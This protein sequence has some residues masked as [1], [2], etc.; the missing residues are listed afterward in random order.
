MQKPET[1]ICTHQFDCANKFNNHEQRIS[2][3]EAAFPRNKAGNLAIERHY[4]FHFEEEE[5]EREKEQAMRKYKEE[6]TKRVIHAC[7][8]LAVIA[9]G[10]GS[11]D[12]ESIFEFVKKIVGG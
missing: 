11:I 4:D 10:S 5:E 7:I 1:S 2:L 9:A 8:G 6:F 12:K 3:I